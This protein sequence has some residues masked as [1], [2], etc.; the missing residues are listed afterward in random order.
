MAAEAV[1]SRC[2]GEGHRAAACPKL[3]FFRSCEYCKQVGHT[4]GAC[5][6]LRQCTY[7]KSEGHTKLDCPK[8]ARKR[9]Q[10]SKP[11][12]SDE[13]KSETSEGSNLQ[14]VVSTASTWATRSRKQKPLKPALTEEQEKEA[15]KMEKKL[16]EIAAL[17]TRL[18][19]GEP[20]DA[21]QEQKLEN[22]SKFEDCEVMLLV[23]SGYQRFVPA[24]PI[25]AK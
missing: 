21:L 2:K 17:E 23:R 8:L 7:C 20:L 5:P 24:H 18:A 9:L 4:V 12:V 22:K 3:P 15:R 19:A 14:S 25:E 11:Q 10:A 6:A 13:S 16:R 1:C